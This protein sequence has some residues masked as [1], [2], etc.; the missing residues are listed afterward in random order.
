MVNHDEENMAQHIQRQSRFGVLE[1]HLKIKA[2]VSAQ[3]YMYTYICNPDDV[4]NTLSAKKPVI[5]VV[6]NPTCILKPF[7]M[8]SKQNERRHHLHL[9]AVVETK[10]VT[11]AGCVPS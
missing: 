2:Y 9:L 3:R 8:Q 1:F 5:T 7:P 6:E 10:S 11:V 4:V